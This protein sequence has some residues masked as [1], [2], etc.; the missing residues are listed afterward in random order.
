MIDRQFLVGAVIA[1][2]IML[3]VILCIFIYLV[4]KGTKRNRINEKMNAYFERYKTGWYNYLV[5]N[6]PFDHR[7]ENKVS[8]KAIDHLFV[9]Y[10]TTVN[11]EVIKTK[12][13]A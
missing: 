3:I 9:S 1:G 4:Y 5:Y 2:T 7:P 12:V 10:L 8:M 6:E 11:N 13:L